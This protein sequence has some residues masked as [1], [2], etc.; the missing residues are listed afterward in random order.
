MTHRLV[1]H[2]DEVIIEASS[3]A[4]LGALEAELRSGIAASFA[5]GRPAAFARSADRLEARH[6]GVRGIGAAIA[7]AAAPTAAA[8]PSTTAAAPTRSRP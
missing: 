3:A 1:V 2:I 5:S 7:G 6:A 8:A 4:E